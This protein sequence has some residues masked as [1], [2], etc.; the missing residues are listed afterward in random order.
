MSNGID[1]MQLDEIEVDENNLYREEIITDLRVATIR[2]MVPIKIDGSEDP[3]R[4]T[5]YMGQT[6]LMSQAGPVPVNA[7]IEGANLKEAV[8]NFPAAI[9]VGIEQLV[10]EVREMQRQEANRIV[11]P[12]QAGIAP[13]IIQG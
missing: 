4:E 11:T 12:Q 6:Q 3:D 1:R 2:R 9:K 13:K 5:L 7:K 10:E 8:A